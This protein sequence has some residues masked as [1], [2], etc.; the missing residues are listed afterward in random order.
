M[1]GGADRG[2]KGPTHGLGSGDVSA[3]EKDFWALDTT[4]G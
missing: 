4:E 3:Y 2:L 1:Q